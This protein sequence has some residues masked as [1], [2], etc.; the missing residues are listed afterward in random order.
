M[1]RDENGGKLKVERETHEPEKDFLFSSQ[2]GVENFEFEPI[3]MCT[4]WCII[5]SN[6]W[7]TVCQMVSSVHTY[8]ENVFYV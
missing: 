1:S 8:R 7:R 2:L 4:H 5:C 6:V 3:K